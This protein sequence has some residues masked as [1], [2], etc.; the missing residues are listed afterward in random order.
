MDLDQ[1]DNHRVV[2]RGLNEALAC[3]DMLAPAPPQ[4]HLLA[5]FLA[6]MCAGVRWRAVHDPLSARSRSRRA[7]LDAGWRHRQGDAR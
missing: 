5:R 4:P 7:P 3:R 2:A 1:D 6:W